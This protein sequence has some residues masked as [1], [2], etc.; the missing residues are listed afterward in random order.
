MSDRKLA[1]AERA[2]DVV[3]SG[4]RIVDALLL[5]GEGVPMLGDVC[6]V[7][8]TILNHVQAF[9][10]KVDDVLEM[11]ER[12]RDALQLLNRMSENMRQFPA[13]EELKER[14]RELHTVLSDID[15]VVASFGDK[16]WMKR[17][18]AMRRKHSK[19]LSELDE[20]LGRSLESLLRLY[21]MERDAKLLAPRTYPLEAAV[22][23]RISEYMHTQGASEEAAM[24]A[25]QRSEQTL[26]E[27]AAELSIADEELM[28]ELRELGAEV[29]E[30]FGHVQAGQAE[31]KEQLA[32]MEAKTAAALKELRRKPANGLDAYEYVARSDAGTKKGKRAALLGRGTFGVTY[33]MR[34]VGGVAQTV[35]AVKIVHEDAINEH[36][37]I[38]PQKLEQEAV[39]L[40]QLE[41]PHIVRYFEAF[42][43][44]SDDD[45]CQFVIVTELLSGGTYADH[46]RKQPV[47][48]QVCTWVCMIASALSYMHS[49]SMQHRDLKPDN[50]LFDKHERPKIIDLGLACTLESK[51]RVSTKQGGAV[52]T[53]LY[54]SPE[55]GSGKS[56]DGKDD[57]W[58]LGCMLAGGVLG[59]P[60]EDMGLNTI[61]IFSLNRPGV[62]K[63]VADATKASA[64]LGG[65]A[66][67]MLAQEPRHRPTAQQIV[68]A[69]SGGLAMPGAGTVPAIPEEPLPPPPPPQAPVDLTDLTDEG[70]SAEREMERARHEATERSAREAR[71]RMRAAAEVR[72][73]ERAQREA[74]EREVTETAAAER[75][76][77]ERAA[78]ERAAALQRA[79]PP[80][81][82]D[83]KQLLQAMQYKKKTLLGSESTESALKRLRLE[84][85]LTLI[86]LDRP[87]SA[88]HVKTLASL[89]ACVDLANLRSLRSAVSFPR[90]GASSQLQH[91]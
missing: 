83:I 71:E 29:R 51:S 24:T 34:K 45:G 61:G 8:R 84:T 26:R 41:H 10:E 50:V 38:A 59:K 36:S 15:G 2:I 56:Y 39:Q 85:Q 4:A 62:N 53:N 52:G 3:K 57:V 17:A 1:R 44:E 88:Y 69:L 46:V 68:E 79:G 54:M 14:W 77:A 33:Q 21:E 55:K 74:Q 23:Q 78:V 66:T 5:I 63:L 11:G 64:R 89:L 30:G 60:L 37:G 49:L 31:I 48:A 7:A 27:M 72:E 67:R 58:A 22:E 13:T 19:A 28:F 70:A 9:A 87:L 25:L 40:A 42:W 80:P 32:A 35:V 91:V 47:E 43:H 18:I 76:A 90:K 16:G 73:E 75:A 82:Q 65:A 6:R 86:S 20:R 81:K 12:V